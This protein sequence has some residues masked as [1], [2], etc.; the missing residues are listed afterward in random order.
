L[1]IAPKNGPSRPP[2]NAGAGGAAHSSLLFGQIQPKVSVAMTAYNHEKF[3][4]QAIESVLMQDTDFPV[5][6]VIGEDCSTDGT[7][8]I[9]QAYAEK[10]PKVIRALLHERNLGMNKNAIKTFGSCRG[11]FIAV[12]EGDDYWTDPRKLQKQVALMEQ[13][14][15]CSMCATAARDVLLSQDGKEQEIGLFPGGSSK[16]M[17]DLEDVLAEYPFRTLTF[18]LRNGLVNLPACFEKDG[19]GDMYLLALYAEKGPIAY[20]SEVT[21]TYRQHAGGVWSGASCTEKC[22]VIRRTLEVLNEHFS[23]RY[24]GILRK[25]DFN[26]SKRV[27]LELMQQGRGWEA[28]QIYWESFFHFERH[29][30]FSYLMFGFSVHAGFCTAAWHRLTIRAAIRTRIKKLIYDYR[31]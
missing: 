19:N 21:S 31:R 4:A 25:R 14:P 3:I 9:V 18:L 16:N 13:N 1:I 29:M 11:E 10:N 20:L 30:P 8:R 7:R 22:K 26:V 2:E 5:E 23:G 27:C 24:L 28:K 15:Q 6:L 12:L 17:Y